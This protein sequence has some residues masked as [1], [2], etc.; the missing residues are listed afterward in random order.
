M[1]KAD[2]KNIPDRRRI[3]V[4]EATFQYIAAHNTYPEGLGDTLD[5]LLRLKK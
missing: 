1:V 3:D 5:R 4:S 2:M